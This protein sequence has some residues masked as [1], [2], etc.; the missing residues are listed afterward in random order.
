MVANN[1][2]MSILPKLDL[3]HF[4]SMVSVY[5]LDPPFSRTLGAAMKS[6]EALSPAARK[7][8][9]LTEDILLSQ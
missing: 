1:L 7:F 6:K 3:Q 9:K 2:G 4:E 5:P 8:L